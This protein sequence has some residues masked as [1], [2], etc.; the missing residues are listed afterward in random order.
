MSP[1]TIRDDVTIL[2][3]LERL[4]VTTARD[5]IDAT[6]GEDTGAADAP[7]SVAVN[8][9]RPR[10]RVHSRSPLLIAVLIILMVLLAAAGAAA[11]LLISEGSPL[12]SPHAADLAPWEHPV[13]GSVTL[14][15]LDAPDPEGGA[16][17]DMRI[18][19]SSTGETCTAV[20]QIFNGKFG[21]V[22]LD[23][24]FRAL[25]LTG[26]D[27]C[28]VPGIAG[29]VLAGARQFAGL[30]TGEARTVVNGIAGTG[31]RAVVAYGLGGERH[32]VLG[33]QGS[34]ITA[35][36]GLL[37][38]VKPRIVVVDK[39][40]RSHTVSFAASAAFETADPEGGAPWQVSG[41]AA[42]GMPGAT[43]D[44]NCASASQEVGP[45]SSGGPLNEAEAPGM[46]GKLA[47]EPLFVRF[48]R[49]DPGDGENTGNPWGNNPSRT[50]VYG[51]ASLRVKTLTLS[52]AGHAREIAIDPHGGAFLAVLPGQVDPHT[53]TL[54]A[55]LKNG[56]TIRYTRST[57]LFG[58]QTGKPIQEGRVE[59][60]R[61]VIHA[62][63]IFAP[64]EDPIPK[65]VVEQL[66][67]DDPAG[68]PAWTLRSWQGRADPRAKFGETKHPTRFYCLQAGV[69]S[70]GRLVEPE[71]GAAAIPLNV[72]TAS[73]GEPGTHCTG[74]G[75]P[76]AENL[77][78]SVSASP[79]DPSEYAPLPVRTLV[80]GVIEPGATHPMLLGAGPPRPITT[81]AN[82]AYLLVLPGSYWASA[83]RASAHL[84]NGRILISS[85]E[86]T[87]PNLQPQVRAPSPDGSAPWGF[88]KTSR[89]PIAW[90]FS[91]IGRVIDGRFADIVTGTGQV[92]AGPGGTSTGSRCGTKNAQAQERLEPLG[93]DEL[94]QPN[95][96]LGIT[97]VHS[98]PEGTHAP[99]E[100]QIQRRTVPGTT[101]IAGDAAADVT[102]VT[103]ST[104]ADV[105]TVEPAGPSHVF[106]VV[107]D[108]VFYRGTFTATTLLKNGKTVTQ[109]IRGG[110][111]NRYA[112]PEPA[113]IPLPTRLHSDERTLR[114][115]NAQ[116]TAVLHAK[117]TQRAK[118]LNGVPLAQLLRGL[119]QIRA[120]VAGEHA[121][122]AFLRNNPGILPPE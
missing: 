6:A 103:L 90:S 42:I 53:L 73:P 117:P 99:T 24:V 87:A 13:P 91:E 46:C 45:G 4:L 68:G 7:S 47:A 112:A 118:L 51:G 98:V 78:P 122:I 88:T 95:A 77:T 20:G 38:E 28:G 5:R 3:Q 33:P 113:P 108:G 81:D 9:G 76:S 59:P 69:I 115:M 75:A 1:S 114:G 67:A 11:V 71:P 2:P 23:H 48:Q 100:A 120:D 116:V 94:G 50:L 52:G 66:H 10:G 37:S 25:P 56:R 15:G 54:T 61:P 86:S 26:V 60:N 93:G 62:G 72:S 22:G 89:C 31:A 30:T 97:V 36:Q 14:A 29:P 8:S 104:P 111:Y 55:T 63:S 12:P 39:F 102:S 17:W 21:T 84:P 18:F 41:G 105:R 83:L 119:H 85:A 19:K 32:L 101:V 121:R 92:A 16:P 109:L 82:H 40:G 110:P 106:I 35:Y 79:K 27:A 34:F 44:E 70:R 57:A 49:F 74:S 43:G 64:L 65:T 58:E 107:Y 80:T 96:P